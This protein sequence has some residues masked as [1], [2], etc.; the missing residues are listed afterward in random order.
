MNAI[1]CLQRQI[2]LREWN[3]SESQE[4]PGDLYDLASV[5]L[6]RRSVGSLSFW[7][8]EHQ[9]KRFDESLTREERTLVDRV[10]LASE[11]QII[12]REWNISESQEEPGDLYDLASVKLLRRS[13][14]SLSFWRTEHQLK[15]F[16]E[17]LTREERTLVDRVGLASEKY[18]DFELT[19]QQEY[20][21]R[22]VVQ[23]MMDRHTRTILDDTDEFRQIILREWNISESQ[24]EPGDLYDLASVKLLRRSDGSLYFWRTEHQ[25]RRFDESLTREERELW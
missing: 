16:D 3:I 15:R 7:R 12:L 24:E 1:Y 10:G 18:Y 14:G 4:E 20:V 9:L 22:R 8:T 23:D 13:V 21:T 17:S 2:I 25:L 6:L 19:Y 5:K 11:K